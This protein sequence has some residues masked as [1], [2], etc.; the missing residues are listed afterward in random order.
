[1]RT[2]C[3]RRAWRRCGPST[4]TA[5]CAAKTPTPAATASLAS[6]TASSTKPTSWGSA[7]S[8][9]CLSHPRRRVG[10]ALPLLTSPVVC[11]A[12]EV[13]VAIDVATL[14]RELAADDQGGEVEGML[15]VGIDGEGQVCG[16]AVNP[17]H[18]GLS[19]VKVWELSALAEELEACSLVVALFPP[20]GADAPSDHEVS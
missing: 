14:V 5:R 13:A 19:F 9:S 8:P 2:T 12:R 3:T 20:G 4:P 7:R 11:D 10:P 18:R 15:V 1:M 17:R 6:P 16:V